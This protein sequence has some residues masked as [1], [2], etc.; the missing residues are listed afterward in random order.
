[1]NIELVTHVVAKA[2]HITYAPIRRAVSPGA[3]S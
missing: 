1:M 2:T 3:E